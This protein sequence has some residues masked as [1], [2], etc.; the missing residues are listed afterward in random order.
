MSLSDAELARGVVTH[1]SGNHAAALCYAASL[2]G[3]SATV[4]MPSN[5]NEVK[6]T[7]VRSYGGTII[8]CEPNTQAREEAMAQWVERHQMVPVVPFDDARVIAG[9]GTAAL[10]FFE[11][12]PELECLIAPVGGGGMLS[13]SVISAQALKP[14]LQVF[15]A[16]PANADDSY[17][18]LRA[19]HRCPLEGT[20]DT[21]ADGLRTSIGELTFPIIQ[22]GV[23]D[24]LLASEQSIIAAMRLVW[25]RMKILI[26]PSS[27]VALAVLIDNPTVL[28][29]KRTGIILTGGNVDLDQLPWNT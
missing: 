17:Q 22:N 13:G 27:A 21:L 14:Q 20:P 2:R 19:G 7:A 9:Q 16:E 1:S 3:T 18:S 8:E 4:V 26:E 5:A 11:Q 29:G 24:I 6:K 23:S 10:E 28:A 12:V 25:E 15:G